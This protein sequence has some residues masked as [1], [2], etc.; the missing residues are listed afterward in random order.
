MI[1]DVSQVLAVNIELLAKLV[2]I[3]DVFFLVDRD[4]VPL[5]GQISKLCALFLRIRTIKL[6]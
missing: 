6:K 5:L 4:G 3:G 2:V 1:D